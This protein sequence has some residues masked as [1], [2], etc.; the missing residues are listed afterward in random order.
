MDTMKRQ[1]TIFRFY[2]DEDLLAWLKAEADRRRTSAA[3]VLR[4][5]VVQA[6]EES[7][8]ENPQGENRLGHT[9]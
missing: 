3:Q 7:S 8:G 9:P 1:K 5:L 2:V 4:E 6:M